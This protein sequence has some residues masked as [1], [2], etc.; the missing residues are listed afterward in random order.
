VLPF[1]ICQKEQSKME[2]LKKSIENVYHSNLEKQKCV[3]LPILL[4]QGNES[5]SVASNFN[6]RLNFK[7]KN[8]Q[9]GKQNLKIAT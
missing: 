2:P 9:P 7:R 5:I 4:L 1:R 3:I 8:F 6:S